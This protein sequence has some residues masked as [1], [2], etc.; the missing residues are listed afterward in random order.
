MREPRALMATIATFTAS[1][2]VSHC[3]VR[4]SNHRS[5]GAIKIK[6]VE[7]KIRV[8]LK[9]ILPATMALDSSSHARATLTSSS[10]AWRAA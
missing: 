1:W 2:R 7:I 5:K 3:T 8:F 9:S 10:A 4:D 6:T